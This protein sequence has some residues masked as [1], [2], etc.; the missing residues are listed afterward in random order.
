MYN[1]QKVIEDTLKSVLEQD[2]SSI[3]YIVIDGL[4]KDNTLPIVSQYENRIQQII[5]EKDSGVYDAMNK[6]IERATGEW[7]LF[8]NAG[9]RFYSP[10]TLSDFFAA[11]PN[12]LAQYDVLYGN[13]EFRLKNIA[14]IVEASN[15]VTSNEYMPF[16][17]Q[18][19]FTRTDVA[20]QNK[21]DLKYRIAADTAFFLR[22]VK[23]NHRFLH[24]PVTVCSYN[25]LEGLS[26]SNEVQRCKEIVA[27]QAQWNNINPDNPYFKKYIRKAYLRQIVRKLT[28]LGIWIRMREKAIYKKHK[29]VY[30][31]EQ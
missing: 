21:F 2:Y 30:K 20:K 31:I 4:S 29:T 3:E 27:L 16:S 17:H 26:V 28:P 11:C 18:A 10:A 15:G 8:M 19:A 7:I 23:E 12:T 13:A 5:S 9:D 1:G 6:G 24:I 14:Y 25:A 22:L